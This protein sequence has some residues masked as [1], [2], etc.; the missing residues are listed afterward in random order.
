MIWNFRNLIDQTIKAY[1]K[2]DLLILNA[3]VSFHAALSDIKDITIYKRLMDV[4]YLGY[5]YP[6]FYALPHLKK[7]KGQIGVVGSLS[8]IQILLDLIDK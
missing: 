4:N 7:S 1:G 2:I 8:G 6:T 3:G 5:V